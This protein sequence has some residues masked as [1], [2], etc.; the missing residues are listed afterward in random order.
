MIWAFGGLKISSFDDS[1]ICGL[2]DLVIWGFGGLVI[3]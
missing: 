1:W 3:W 2:V